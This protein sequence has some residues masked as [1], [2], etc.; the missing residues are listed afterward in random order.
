MIDSLLKAYDWFDRLFLARES[1]L[2]QD[3]EDSVHGR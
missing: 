1:P 2:L 3:G